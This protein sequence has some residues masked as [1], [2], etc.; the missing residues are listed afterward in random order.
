MRWCDDEEPNDYE[1][2]LKYSLF[3]KFKVNF[4]YEIVVSSSFTK[5]NTINV[6]KELYAIEKQLLQHTVD[7]ALLCGERIIYRNGSNG[8]LALGKSPSDKVDQT[9]NTC[10]T[11]STNQNCIPINGAMTVICDNCE[12]LILQTLKEA[13]EIMNFNQ[14]EEVELSK[15]ITN[16]TFIGKRF[17]SG[18]SSDI[19]SAGGRRYDSFSYNAAGLKTDLQPS[20][21]PSLTAL[22]GFLVGVFILLIITLSCIFHRR[23]QKRK[24]NEILKKNKL[25]I[26]DTD[27]TS[28]SFDDEDDCT[29]D[30]SGN[31]E[32]KVTE[33]NTIS[34]SKSISEEE[35]QNKQDDE[36]WYVTDLF[37][38]C[39]FFNVYSDNTCH[40]DVIIE[41]SLKP[42]KTVR[43]IE[44]DKLT[45]P[46]SSSSIKKNSKLAKKKR[47]NASSSSSRIEV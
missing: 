36:N 5:N 29:Y 37:N 42:K 3:T 35:G 46:L 31:Y 17:Y 43:W 14:N 32:C 11:N 47:D 6:S 19:L 16:I 18:S 34:N 39:D 33:M 22:G 2:L 21:S 38:Y 20:I 13:M 23:R 45:P 40:G 25:R 8:I 15:N 28:S 41:T 27:P 1:K 9:L 4:D 10:V 44:N 7:N 26:V 12:L 24:R 30:D